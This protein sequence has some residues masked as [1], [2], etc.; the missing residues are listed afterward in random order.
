MKMSVASRPALRR[1]VLAAAF[2]LVAA[3]VLLSLVERD[4]SR[5]FCAAL[6]GVLVWNCLKRFKLE[7][8]I[9]QS[10]GES[11]GKVS[12]YRRIG[13]KR[14]C[15]IDYTFPTSENKIYVGS[16]QAYDGLP[17]EGQRFLVVY[18]LADPSINLPLFS[19]WFYRFAFEP[20]EKAIPSSA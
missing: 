3:L 16:H 20:S 8:S 11:M 2:C 15:T 6:A 12:T 7:H 14:G 4:L 9:V 18:N 1:A 19:F 17:Q 5:I 10:H 13:T